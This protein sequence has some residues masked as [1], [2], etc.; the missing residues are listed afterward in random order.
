MYCFRIHTFKNW[1]FVTRQRST[2]SHK[3]IFLSKYGI[4]LGISNLY[5]IAIIVKCYLHKLDLETKYVRVAFHDWQQKFVWLIDYLF[6]NPSW[7][8]GMVSSFIARR[9]VRPQTQ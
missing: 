1:G 9:W 3:T 2:K 5:V 8:I 4:F 7:F 6:K